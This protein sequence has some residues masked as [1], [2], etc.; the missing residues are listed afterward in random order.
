[1]LECASFDGGSRE[2]SALERENL[3]LRVGKSGAAMTPWLLVLVTGCAD[4]GANGST[5]GGD[6]EEAQIVAQAEG[7]HGNALKAFLGKL[8]FEDEQLS[9]PAGQSCA[10]CH[11][12]QHAFTDPD[13]G[14]PTSAGVVEGR[15]G[16]RNSPMAAYAAFVPPLSYDSEEGLFIGGLFLDGRVSSLEEQAA[17]PFL[18]ALEMNNASEAA[19]VKKLKRRP[20]A[21]LF[22]L[23]Y[24]PSAFGSVSG[25]YERMTQAIAAFERTPVFAPFSSKYDAYL[26][27]RAK[28][29]PRERRGLEL[30]N[31][32]SKGNCAA[33]HPSAASEDGTPPM[34]TD[35]TFDNIGVPK[36]PD[37][38]FYGLPTDF[39]PDGA[40]FLDRGLGATVDDASL[41]GAFRVASLRNVALTA[42]YSHNGFFSDLRSTVS[43]Y[44]TRDVGSWPAPEFPDTMNRDELGNL[45]LDD[46]E[47][48]D[49]VA[50]LKTLTDGYYRPD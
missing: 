4:G 50:F 17:K 5:A 49:I 15:F 18:N 2:Q 24:G 19:V 45:G 39:N 48:D 41:D 34:F 44:N 20:Y 47:V 28:L 29:S 36:N 37:N 7:L 13:Q 38:P 46:G 32:P 30:F 27:G 11:D 26:A 1:M 12:R 3:M 23:V 21:V 33:C 16:V 31:D 22:N 14:I 6:D 8:I 10:S 9:T 35:F 42:P 25:A 40:D 43:F